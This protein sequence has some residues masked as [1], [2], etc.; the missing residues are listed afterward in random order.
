LLTDGSVR[1]A[2][3]VWVQDNAVHYIT[4]EGTG[5]RLDLYYINREGTRMAN[6]ARHLALALP[7]GRPSRPSR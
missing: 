5:R 1:P 2:I 4:P 7:A 6:A 3:A